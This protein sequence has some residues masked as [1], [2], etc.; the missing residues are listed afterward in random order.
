MRA[1]IL[2][3]KL[4]STPAF[5]VGDDYILS[6]DVSRE[7]LSS[8][9]EKHSAKG[10]PA[11]WERFTDEEKRKAEDVI[12]SR[13]ASLNFLV[14]ALAGLGDGINPCAFATIVFFISYLTMIQ[15]K[16]REILAVGFAFA[17]SVFVTYFLVG[18]GFFNVLKTAIDIDLVA[19]I[20]FG[21]TAL[22]C[23]VFGI[24][25]IGDYLKVRAGKTSEMA[26]QL[27]GFLKKKIHATIR[28][29]ARMKSFISGALI[30]GFLV[31]I[32][33]FACTGQVYLP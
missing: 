21:G 22:L 14:I 15:R 26:L 20:V 33:E 5:F 23:I 30:A 6:S 24:L 31:S 17:F 8:L 7:R 27:P 28:E 2:D 13:F 11:G 1:G 19:K 29:K 4:M 25:S 9:V 18:L 32:F 12:R 10:A 3:R 16:G